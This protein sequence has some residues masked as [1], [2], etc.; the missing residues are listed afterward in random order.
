MRWRGRKFNRGAAKRRARQHW[1]IWFAWH[2][3]FDDEG[4]QWLWLEKVRRIGVLWERPGQFGGGPVECWHWNCRA[5]P[6]PGSP[7][8]QSGRRRAG[9][10]KGAGLRGWLN[11]TV[12]ETAVDL[13]PDGPVVVSQRRLPRLYVNTDH[14][15]PGEAGEVR[16]RSWRERLCSRPWRPWLKYGL[17]RVSADS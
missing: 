17:Y 3:V 15:R 7:G 6:R 1:H 8:R 14:L 4:R 12:I 10:G 2:P 9:Y 16:Q 5:I 13:T 11:P